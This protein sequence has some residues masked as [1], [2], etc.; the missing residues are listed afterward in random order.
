MKRTLFIVFL[1]LI[2][3]LTCYL[4]NTF[5]QNY[6]Q[7]SLPEGAK[8]RLGKGRLSG[9]T[10][11]IA[12]SPSGNHLA[13]ASGIGIWIYDVETT[14]E[15]ALLTEN[16]GAIRS[17]SY[18]PDGTLLASGASDGIVKL[19]DIAKRQTIATLEG[20]IV[21][22]SSDGTLLA[23]AT[24]ATIKLWDITTRENIATLTGHADTVNC[25]AF[26]PDGTLLASGA[27]GGIVKL[28]DI[29]KRQTIATLIVDT[30]LVS[31]VAFSPDGKFLVSGASHEVQLWDV[32]THQN[33]FSFEARTGGRMSLAFSPSGKTLAYISLSDVRLW[34]VATKTDIATLRGRGSNLF[35][36]AFSPDGTTLA[37]G[38]WDDTVKLWNTESGERIATLEGHTGGSTSVAFSPDGTTLVSGSYSYELKLWDV[39]TGRNTVTFGRELTGV[40]SIAYS[41]DGKWLITGEGHPVQVAQGVRDGTVNLWDVATKKNITA[42]VG[43]TNWV[44]SVAFSPDG[45]TIASG[46]G[47]FEDYAIRLWDAQSS[48]HLK[49]LMG[50]TERTSSVA[51]SPDSNTL[52]SGSWDNTVRL[53]DVATG[54]QKN[55]LTEHSGRVNSV[56]FSPDGQ[57][58]ASGSSDDTV[59]LW[60]VA[61]GRQKNMLTGHTGGINS[62]A[63]SPD[64]QT[65]ASGSSDG[66]IL[67]WQST[68]S[69]TS[70]AIVRLLPASVASPR[71]GDQ[72]SLSVDIVAA[73]NVAGYQATVRFDT[74][75][76]RYVSSANGDFLSAGA[77]FVKPVIEG[78]LIMLNAASFAGETDGAGTLATLKFEVIEPKSSIVTLSDVL[79]TNR[80]G[81]AFV[82]QVEDAEITKPTT[83]K[84]DV[85]GDGH[86]NVLDLVIIASNLGKSGQND[87]D[88]NGD[89][90]VNIQDLVLI[91]G[92][93]STSAAAPSSHTQALS[94]L[95]AIDVKRW[96]SQAQ[97]LNFIDATSLQGIRFLEQLLAA[98][99]P[100]ETVLLAN[101]PNPFNPETWIPY[102][103]AAPADVSISIYTADGKLVQILAL[104]HQA[105]GIYESRSRAVYWD[106]K[107]QLGEP[108]ASGIYFYTLTADDFTAT[109]KMV[110]RK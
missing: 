82:P 91:A 93:L 24:S 43:H 27:M 49:T 74:T 64:G 36:V 104:G 86:V 55:M 60:E 96:L 32:E 65:L 89:G 81:E 92:V 12:F 78:N 97:Q 85:N 40:S 80:A 37:A 48:T 41:P 44:Y 67:L 98:L 69:L 88:V 5:A 61:T 70:D 105:I 7:L 6:T 106:G 58:L 35:S 108:V 56:A 47:R 79:L 83:L 63:F 54:R 72:L 51:F 84:S 62:V 33:I 28:W 42:L 68:P 3:L 17:V 100:K 71:I 25:I 19:W 11:G 14:Q 102:Q 29:A 45:R 20:H 4:S 34:D 2:S 101:Y 66:T 94:I 107:N 15:H 22:Y 99:T 59:R 21:S 57:T 46:G 8:A 23:S 9:G 77:L 73:E 39:A 53:W 38:S 30:W 90:I 109:R 18:S 16:V 52:A 103:L 26:S 95:T 13:V 75:A 110:I 1:T 76:L 50:H 87:A 31:S 10:R